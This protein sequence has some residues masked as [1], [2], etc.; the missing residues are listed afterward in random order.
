MYPLRFMQC[1]SLRGPI[2]RVIVLEIYY[3]YSDI[4]EC[5]L[6]MDAHM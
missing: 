1:V 4:Y 5:M 2:N 3:S 6:C